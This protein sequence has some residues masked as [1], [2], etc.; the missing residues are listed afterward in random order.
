MP[1]DDDLIW[2]AGEQLISTERI[3]LV[4]HKRPDGDAIGSLLGLGLPLGSAGKDVQM[5]SVDGVPRKLQYLE[6]SEQIQKRVER[7]FD[8]VCVLDSSDLERTGDVLNNHPRPDINIDHHPTN[9]TYARLNL[10]DVQAVSTTQIIA[11]ILSR[12]DLPLTQPA[13]DAILTG[14]IT[15]TLGFRTA[16]MNSDALR[17][18]ADL[19]DMGSNLHELYR[20]A[21]V[22]RSF[23]SARLW[24]AGLSH[25]KR[26][27]GLVWTTISLPDRLE[28]GYP[29]W[30]DADLVNVLVSVENAEIA[31]IF[32]EQPGERVKVSWR[33]RP[34]LDV[35]FV[36]SQFGG[37]GHANAAGAEI[38]GSLDDV[39][40]A[41]L[42]ITK[43]LLEVVP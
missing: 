39:Q 34:D 19:V 4:A 42:E 8:L 40:K 15:D 26:D 1:L 21:L 37:G 6:G 7:E 11:K 43:P 9:M 3:L 36:A 31:M 23:E 28:A 17:L 2:S 33:S 41:V 18:A 20:R 10:V 5:V 13:A 14:L 35:S 29:G 32:M 27:G 24:G 22:I 12:I 25:I 16:N 38:V 30:D